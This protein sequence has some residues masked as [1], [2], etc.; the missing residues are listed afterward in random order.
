MVDPQGQANKWVKEM[1]GKRLKITDLK[2]KDFIREL[3]NAIVYGMPYLL[4]DVEEVCASC[5]CVCLHFGGCWFRWSL[6]CC[7]DG[8]VDQH[9]C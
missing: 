1:E 8:V 2:A 5:V 9:V 6:V 4:Q 3:E 7:P